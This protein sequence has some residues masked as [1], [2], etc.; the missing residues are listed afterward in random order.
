M[1]WTIFTR[2]GLLICAMML[3]AMAVGCALPPFLSTAEPLPAHQGI[4]RPTS[5]DAPPEAPKPFYYPQKPVTLLVGSHR[6]TDAD[7]ATRLLATQLE[8]VIGAPVVVSNRPEDDGIGIWNQLKSAGSDGYNLGLISSPQMQAMAM[9]PARNASFSLKDFLPL[10]GHIKDPTVLFVRSWGPFNSVEELMEAARAQPEKITIS[11][12]NTS[13]VSNLAMDEFQ[14][15]TGLKLR[16]AN[17]TDP[18]NTLLAVLNGQAEAAFISFSRAISMV[19]A[20][21]G[22]F[23]A[24]MSDE[25]VQ[26]QPSVPALREKGINLVSQTFLGYVAPRK[27]AP[28]IADYLNWSLYLAISNANHQSD[29][30]KAGLAPRYMES[31]RFANLLTSE[32]GRV[33][34]LRRR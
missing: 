18:T 31:Q 27:T 11:I 6:G 19:R 10:A 17:S 22:R 24:V 29:L 1:P 16:V 26:L 30:Q 21:Q 13:L 25:R 12:T 4:A 2:I 34:R 23:L 15:I 5:P 7:I 28:D 3:S 32:W 8:M 14:R 9:E 20:G 33:E